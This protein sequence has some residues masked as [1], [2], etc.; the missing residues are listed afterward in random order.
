MMINADLL[1]NI[2]KSNVAPLRIK[3]NIK[4]GGVNLS[5]YS[6]VAFESDLK[7][8]TIAPAIIHINKLDNSNSPRIGSL[9]K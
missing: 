8:T 7:F 2:V 5:M 6:N 1:A 4:K 9:N 3:N